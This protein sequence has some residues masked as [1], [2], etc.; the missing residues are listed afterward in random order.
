MRVIDE[1][2]AARRQMCTTEKELV[3]LYVSIIPICSTYQNAFLL[4]FDNYFYDLFKLR[5][6]KN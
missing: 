5:Y 1:N 3:N 4:F 2:S 6:N